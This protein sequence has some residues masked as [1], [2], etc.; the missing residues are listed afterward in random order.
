MSVSAPPTL[1][2]LGLVII[3]PVVLALSA[4]GINYDVTVHTNETADVTLLFWGLDKGMTDSACSADA[5][6]E[7]ALFPSGAEITYTLTEHNGHPACQMSAE[8]VP[9]SQFSGS[10]EG[11]SITHTNG[12]FEV[13]LPSTDSD[14]MYEGMDSRCTV[15]FPGRVV[16]ASGNATIDGNTVTWDNYLTEGGDLHAVGKDS[17]GPPWAWI[18]VG[19]IAVM[20]AGGGAALAVIMIRRR[21]SAAGAAPG[22]YG[23]PGPP[24]QPDRS[25]TYQPGYAQPDDARPGY[26]RA[27][28]AQTGYAHPDGGRPTQGSPVSTRSW[29]S[30]HGQPDQQPYNPYRQY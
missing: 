19:I 9:V 15:T 13:A 12:R 6:D 24:Y 10:R 4:C 5:M 7:F 8:A 18:G 26:S 17:P 28:A 14:S 2:R 11:L 23:H 27:G 16:E 29:P 21:C 1:R 25:R 3:V 22:P 30:D 20:I